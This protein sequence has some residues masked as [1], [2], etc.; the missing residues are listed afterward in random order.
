[1]ILT[2]QEKLK[3]LMDRDKITFTELARRMDKSPQSIAQI[4]KYDNITL[5]KLEE[6]ATAAGYDMIIEFKKK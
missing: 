6:L 5:E 3:I 4:F 1:M 2:P